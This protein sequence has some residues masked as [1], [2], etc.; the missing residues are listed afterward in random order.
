MRYVR[1]IEITDWANMSEST[2]F[3]LPVLIEFVDCPDTS[4]KIL[5]CDMGWYVIMG[6]NYTNMHLLIA[7]E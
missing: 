2:K 4:W 1:L 3:Y 6:V 5:I 7:Y